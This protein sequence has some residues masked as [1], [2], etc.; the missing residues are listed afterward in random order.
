M[1]H[2]QASGVSSRRR[3]AARGYYG[4]VAERCGAVTAQ[5]DGVSGS[6]RLRESAA[7]L[8]T[9]SPRERGFVSGIGRP[10]GH[11]REPPAWREKRAALCARPPARPCLDAGTNSLQTLPG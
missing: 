10:V 1:D 6:E 4:W 2:L 11:P 8:V 9:A 5:G 7:P 3:L